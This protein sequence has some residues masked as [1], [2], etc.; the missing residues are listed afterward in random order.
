MSLLIP[1][2]TGSPAA[3]AAATD[4]LKPQPV[5]FEEIVFFNLA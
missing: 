1:D 4:A 2:T 5:G 3:H